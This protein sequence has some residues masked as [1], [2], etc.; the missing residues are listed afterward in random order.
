MNLEMSE[1]DRALIAESRPV[2]E[3]VQAAA[4]AGADH[5]H[6]I[7]KQLVSLGWA[8]FG[9]DIMSGELSLGAA[10]GIFREAGRSRIIDQLVNGAYLLPTLVNYLEESERDTFFAALADSPGVF[11]ADGRASA[12]SAVAGNRAPLYFGVEE[13]A[14]PWRVTQGPEQN[15]M[16]GFAKVDEPI[17]FEKT[18]GMAISLGSA[19]TEPLDWHDAS[20]KMGEAELDVVVRRAMLLHSCGLIGAADAS[21]EMTLEHTMN[22]VQF[23]RP[24]ASFQVIKHALADCLTAREVAWSALLCA[25]ADD[26]A[27]QRRALVARILVV[28]AAMEASRTAAQYHGGMGFTWES[29]LHLYLKTILE[30]SIRFGCLDELNIALGRLVAEEAAC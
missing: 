14:K 22:R 5:D 12:L 13:P 16:L 10:G 19:Q 6:H 27:D 2:F 29:Q 21:I 1:T 26:A 4:H 23:G 24:I 17:E 15:L 28:R 3:R 20:L 30:G 9:T 7:W 11:W 18:A 25:M 8:D